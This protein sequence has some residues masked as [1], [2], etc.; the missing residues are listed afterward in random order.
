MQDLKEIDGLI[1]VFMNKELKST[2]F[3]K[4][5]SQS[6]IRVSLERHSVTQNI[7]FGFRFPHQNNQGLCQGNQTCNQA[8]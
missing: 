3:Q 8:Q 4:V 1:M 5:N 2:F 7:T 6:M